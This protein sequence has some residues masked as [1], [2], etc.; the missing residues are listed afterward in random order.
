MID[1]LICKFRNL[2]VRGRTVSI[3]EDEGQVYTITTS[4]FGQT[5]LAEC[6]YPYGY[7]ASPPITTLCVNMALSA[8]PENSVSF[9]YN[10]TD[11]WKDLDVGEVQ[12]GNPIEKTYIKFNKDG[13]ITLKGDFH[14]DGNISATGNVSDSETSI[15]DI[16]QAYNNHTHIDSEGGTTSGPSTPL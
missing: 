4:S 6:Y 5:Y 13:T 9:P 15:N 8:Q 10:S 2:L 7:G 16:K 11:R 12:L 3:Q 14:V 1:K